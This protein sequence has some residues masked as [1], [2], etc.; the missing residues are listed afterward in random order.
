M[1][2][3]YT[4]RATAKSGRDGHVST[5]TKTLDHKLS[6][7]KEI[8]GPG[9]EGTNPEE[10]FAAG[11]AACFGAASRLAA[12]QKKITVKDVSITAKVGIGKDAPSFKLAVE[13]IGTFGGVDKKQ[14]EE[15]MHEAHKLCPYSKMS[16]NNIE[17]KLSV[18]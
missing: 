5:D 3:L 16:R 6:V 12:S 11:Y 7:P 13:L 10:L 9:G 8:G 18:A 2:I 17:V 14:A 1:D 4:A 15:I